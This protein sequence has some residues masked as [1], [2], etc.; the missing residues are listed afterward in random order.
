MTRMDRTKI[1]EE[2]QAAL[3]DQ[4]DFLKKALEVFMQNALDSEFRRFISVD[5]YQRAQERKGYRNGSYERQ[6]KTRVGTLLLKVCR[7]REGEFR[8]ELFERYQ[9]SEKA[10]VLGII[11]M[12]LWGVSTRNVE[13]IMEALCGF[14]ASKSQVSALTAQLDSEL[15][16]WRKR[17]LTEQYVYLV[18]DARY[19]KVRE[20]GRVISK[21][22]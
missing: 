19:E 4:P 3:I 21:A 22:F 7:D 18:L 12:Y 13:Q 5:E 10:L 11:E 1:G 14:G 6:L 17:V 9:R 20:N 15:E 2:W 8:T 16:T